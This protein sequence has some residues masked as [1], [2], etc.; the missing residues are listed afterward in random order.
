MSQEKYIGMDVHQASIITWAAV[1]AVGL[2]GMGQE[3]TDGHA[4]TRSGMTRARAARG[5]CC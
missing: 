2:P 5:Q 4:A 1:P 3:R